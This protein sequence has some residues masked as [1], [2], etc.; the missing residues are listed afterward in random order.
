MIIQNI[1]YQ[2]IGITWVLMSARLLWHIFN[3]RDILH[4]VPG[5][6]FINMIWL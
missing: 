1:W 3:T 6:P 5:F 2:G 4:Y